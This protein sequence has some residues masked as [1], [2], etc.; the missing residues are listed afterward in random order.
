MPATGRRAPACAKRPGRFSRRRSAPS[1][2]Q[3]LPT[4][5]RVANSRRSSEGCYGCWPGSVDRLERLLATIAFG[6]EVQVE[7]VATLTSH[8]AHVTRE[9]VDAVTRDISGAWLLMVAM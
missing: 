4:R 2:R 9:Q 7:A 6:W 3:G 8:P 1:A 5:S